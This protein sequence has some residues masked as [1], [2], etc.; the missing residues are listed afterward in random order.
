MS[1]LSEVETIK[2]DLAKLLKNKI[3][4]SITVKRAKFL[5][6]PIARF[7]KIPINKKVKN[8]QRRAKVLSLLMI[9]Q[10][11][12]IDREALKI[13]LEIWATREC[14]KYMVNRK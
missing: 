9:G 5:N 14:S 1:R 10:Q 13:S 12:T 6:M 4:K 7:Q 2:R 11:K 8:I 3:I